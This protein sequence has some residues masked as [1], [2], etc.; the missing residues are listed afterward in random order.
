MVVGNAG[1]TSS[2]FYVL[3]TDTNLT[4]TCKVQPVRPIGVGSQISGSRS[5][6]LK[7]YIIK[8]SHPSII[9]DI[10][11]VGQWTLETVAVPVSVEAE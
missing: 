2:R 9:L 1:D 4:V 11:F 5:R 10:I 3:R 6:R 7:K 8:R